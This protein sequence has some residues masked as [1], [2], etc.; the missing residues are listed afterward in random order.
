MRL[1]V[2]VE[3]PAN[4]RSTLERLQPRL[5]AALGRAARAVT[6]V[7]PDHMHCTLRFFGD[8][9]DDQALRLQ[10]CVAQAASLVPP[11]E[12]CLGTLGVFPEAG[13]PR[14]VWAGL[15]RGQ[16]GFRLLDDS[17]AWELETGGWPREARA[18]HPHITL[19]RVKTNISLAAVTYAFRRCAL[20]N[21]LT[22][23]VEELHLIRSRLGADGPRY[24]TLYSAPLTTAI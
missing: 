24:T 10:H 20:P 8:V 18:L 9:A 2:A 4:I 5:A 23:R 3:L 11:F 14:V 17:L 6:W 12:G 19:G 22:F 13:P 15:S 16:D 1:F 21:Y 7:Q